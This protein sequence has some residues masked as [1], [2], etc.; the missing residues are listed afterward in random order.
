MQALGHLRTA[1]DAP[2]LFGV[3]SVSL[4]GGWSH[5]PTRV[6][7]MGWEWM[8]RPDVWREGRMARTEQGDKEGS[9]WGFGSWAVSEGV[10]M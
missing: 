3:S 7:V 5:G 2:S 4:G 8:Q 10:L 1:R 6:G 9:E